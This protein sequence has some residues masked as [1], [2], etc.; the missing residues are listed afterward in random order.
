MLFISWWTR[1]SAEYQ[2]SCLQQTS[3]ASFNYDP[4][5]RNATSK[6]PFSN[7]DCEELIKAGYAIN[8]GRISLGSG[9][10]TYEKAKQL[11]DKWRHF[12]LKWASVESSTRIRAGERFC[13]CSQELFSWV[14][15]PLEILYVNNYEASNGIQPSPSDSPACLANPS[16]VSK[17]KAAYCFGSGTLQGHLLAGEERFSVELDEDDTVWYEV[18]SFSRPA[19]FLSLIARP[20]IH[21]KQKLFAQQSTQAMLRAVLE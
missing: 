1:P 17:L 18:L 16:K 21:Y 2:A 9:L 10:Q 5:H 13:V 15:M 7:E 14:S 6:A 8:H 4:K 3:S 12:Q 19:H 11:I 20:Y